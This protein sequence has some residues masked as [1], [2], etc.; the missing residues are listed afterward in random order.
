[1]ITVRGVKVFRNV[2]ANF[3]E[4][5]IQPGDDYQIKVVEEKGVN[6]VRIK[7]EMK[8]AEG[9]EETRRAIQDE[10]RSKLNLRV[11]V[12]IVPR[13]MLPKFDYKAK[14][15]IDRRKATPGI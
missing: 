13:G 14:R 1:M 9:K 5:H 4:T 2:L 8:E 11:E 6:E 3:V 10:I 12:E 15:F 7:L